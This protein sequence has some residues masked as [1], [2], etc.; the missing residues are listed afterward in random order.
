MSRTWYS[1]LQSVASQMETSASFALRNVAV[2]FLFR[3]VFEPREEFTILQIVGL[4]Y[5]TVVLYHT[6]I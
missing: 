1:L 4:Y 2:F 6:D 5:T 3:A